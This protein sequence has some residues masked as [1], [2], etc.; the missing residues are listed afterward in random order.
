MQHFWSARVNCPLC[1]HEPDDAYDSYGD[2]DTNDSYE[3]PLRDNYPRVRARL[4]AKAR[5]MAKSDKRM[6]RR[7]GTINKWS[8]IAAQHQALCNEL[9][10]KLRPVEDA[11]NKR[12]KQRIKHFTDKAEAAHNAKYGD[13]IEAHRIARKTARTAL[14]RARASR[15]M[16]V[17]DMW[18]AERA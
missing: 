17:R 18:A 13:L 3:S 11:L 6:A 2:E 9:D 8:S 4:M 12:I 15:R 10:D 5:R 14:G 16:L 1:R 7:V